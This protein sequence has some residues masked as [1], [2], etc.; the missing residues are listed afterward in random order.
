[1]ILGSSKRF[2]EILYHLTNY[3]ILWPLKAQSI[4][5]FTSRIFLIQTADF[6]VLNFF[7]KLGPIS[8]DFSTSTCLIIPFFWGGEFV[9]ILWNGTRFFFFFCWQIWDQK[10]THFYG[11]S[12]Y[13]LTLSTPAFKSLTHQVDSWQL[14]GSVAEWLTHWIKKKKKKKSRGSYRYCWP[15]FKNTL[16]YLL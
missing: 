4:H 8:M 3:I 7:C 5:S 1:M 2:W 16:T 13:T 10:L 12:P 15:Y 9:A 11:T 6:T 14:E